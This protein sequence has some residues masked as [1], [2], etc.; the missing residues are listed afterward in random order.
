[1][2][3]FA[4][5]IF[6][7]RLSEVSAAAIE[8]AGAAVESCIGLLGAMC[9]WTGLSK[10]AEKSGLMQ[11]F[12]KLLRPVTRILFPRLSASSP[13]LCAI[14]MNMVANLLGM[15]N[16]ATPLGIAAMKELDKLNKGRKG[17]SNEMCTFAVINTASIQLIPS[18]MISLRQLY[19]SAN[20]SEIIMPVWIVSLC[21]VTVGVTMTKILQKRRLPRL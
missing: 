9:L 8:G 10:V 12:S 4:V 20:P 7:G 1:M 13:A 14:V 17:A 6:T 5:A 19:G 16:A 11:V 15:G 21:T 3:S 18:T 2:L